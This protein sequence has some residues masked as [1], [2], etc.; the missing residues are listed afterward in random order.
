MA[1]RVQVRSEDSGRRVNELIY[2]NADLRTT[3]N[4]V[5]ELASEANLRQVIDTL[6]TLI[7]CTRTDGSTEFL[8]RR[9]HDYTGCSPEE[10]RVHGWQPTVHPEDLPR[11]VAKG[12]ELVAS[13]Q[14][15]E[16]EAR[17]R[18]H[19]GAF[20]WFLM[21]VEPLRDLAGNIVRWYG[22]QTDIDD[23]KQIEEKLR[24]EDR[25]LRRI[26][27]AIPQT[28]V[29]MDS[30]GAPVYANQA[31]LDYTGLSA[32]DVL[33][34]SFRER[35]THPDGLEKLK[36]QRTAGISRGLPFDLE[37]RA[38]RK[39]GEYRWYLVRFN[40]FRDEAGR[41]VRW[42]A[43]G[44]DI[45]DRVRAE[46]RTRNENQALRE[47]IDRDSMFEDIVGSSEV[48]RKVLRQVTKVAL[49]DSTV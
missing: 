46:E 47:Q 45:D 41:V 33:S 40:P 23:L 43:T 7:W 29:V 49:A 20:R 38:R 44:T 31:M 11:V 36:E 2:S 21:R 18:R 48:L 12:Q 34:S 35:L 39:D 15:G 5:P 17:I 30:S 25:E 10:S 4:V 22:T 13:G 32:E 14:P 8:N 19:D 6:P 16:V 1:D 28:I 9:W 24:E 3:I 37:H 26:T 42:Y 27:D